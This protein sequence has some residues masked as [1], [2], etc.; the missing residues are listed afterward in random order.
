MT[1]R[2]EWQFTCWRHGQGTHLRSLTQS[3]VQN[4]IG[5]V[6]GN[7]KGTTRYVIVGPVE[8]IQSEIGT[9]QSTCKNLRT[10]K[11]EERS[12]T[13]APILASRRPCTFS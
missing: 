9:N 10:Y 8:R 5:A 11:A 1:K 7:A 12:K 3:S 6:G 4:V 13:S 2:Y